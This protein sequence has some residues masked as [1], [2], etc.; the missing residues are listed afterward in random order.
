MCSCRPDQAVSLYF[1]VKDDDVPSSYV[2]LQLVCSFADSSSGGRRK[3]RVCTRRLRSTSDPVSF[4]RSLDTK[5]TAVLML[6]RSILLSLQPSALGG[7]SLP[8]VHSDLKKQLLHVMAVYGRRHQ[9]PDGTGS[10]LYLPAELQ[11]LPVCVYHALRGPMLGTIVQ[12]P[13]DT[14]VQRL[15]F[16]NAGREACSRML[17]PSLLSFNSSGHTDQLAL[18][19]IAQQSN[20][21]LY[22]D[23]HT[24]IFIWSGSSV[25]G[26]EFD[27]YR[28][29]WVQKAE[30]SSSTRFPTPAVYVFTEG[31]S[32]ARWLDCRL[33]PSHKDTPQ[34]METDYPPIALL[35]AEDRSELLSKFLP[36]D[37]LSFHQ[38]YKQLQRDL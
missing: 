25:A 14:C 32:A 3:T 26:P 13:D 8:A 29:A 12:H 1:R 18:C 33:A 31:S 28:S 19:N 22:L 15:V 20:R 16:L 11:Y 7:F 30:S 37:E 17:V 10:G 2:Y 21:L 9:E 23:H 38:F 24:H 27:L 36:T 35:S 5:V 4:L 34:Q 6:K